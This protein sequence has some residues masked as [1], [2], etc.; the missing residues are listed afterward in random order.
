MIRTGALLVAAGQTSFAFPS[1]H[2]PIGVARPQT[3]RRQKPKASPEA[4]HLARNHGL[5][6]L[7]QPEAQMARS[8]K[9]QGSREPKHL[10]QALEGGRYGGQAA[11]EG[12]AKSLLSSTGWRARSGPR[13]RSAPANTPNAH[14]L[15]KGDFCAAAGG[16]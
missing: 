11:Q 15:H 14:P 3:R 4:K 5:K 6:S 8:A 12:A 13:H 7:K 1:F 9:A 2:H 10:Q 16:H